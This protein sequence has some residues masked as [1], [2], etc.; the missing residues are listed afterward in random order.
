MIGKILTNITPQ[1]T[2]DLSRSRDH[3]KKDENQNLIALLA[4]DWSSW[5]LH[6]ARRELAFY[7]DRMRGRAAAI[8]HRDAQP[9]QQALAKTAT[10]AFDALSAELVARGEL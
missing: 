2:A 8:R 5:R 4:G 7:A 3:M 1:D 9:P 6:Q 10:R